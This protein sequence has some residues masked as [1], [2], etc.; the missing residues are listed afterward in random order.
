MDENG[1]P[2]FIQTLNTHSLCVISIFQNEGVLFSSVSKLCRLGQWCHGSCV[3]VDGARWRGE[4]LLCSCRDEGCVVCL[5]SHLYVLV[6]MMPC[7]CSQSQPVCVR[8]SLSI[9]SALRSGGSI[10]TYSYTS[11]Y[12]EFWY[13]CIKY[14]DAMVV[15]VSKLKPL[16]SSFV[17]T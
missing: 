13:Y 11:T 8:V 2:S 12:S 4:Y 15:T 10:F 17:F 7:V 16:L 6:A 3:R 9:L 1:T 14:W 5:H